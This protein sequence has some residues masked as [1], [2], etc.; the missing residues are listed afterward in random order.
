MFQLTK[1]IVFLFTIL[2]LFCHCIKESTLEPI[3]QTATISATIIN[4]SDWQKYFI[5]LSSDSTEFHFVPGISSIYNFGDNQIFAGGGFLRR[6]TARQTV[7]D[8]LVINTTAA[9]L[10]EAVKTGRGSIATK[11]A[12]PGE[13]NI[14]FF[15]TVFYDAD[16]NRTTTADQI[17]LNGS[18]TLDALF[19]LDIE[20]VDHKL[21]KFEI[22]I[23]LNEE[24]DLTLN[25]TQQFTM[26]K[27]IEIA[28][29]QTEPVQFFIEQLPVIVMPIVR[30]TAAING[31]SAKPLTMSMVQNVFFTAGAAFRQ[32]QWNPYCEFTNLFSTEPPVSKSET[33][34]RAV[35][36]VELIF[37]IYQANGPYIINS[38]YNEII[39]DTLKSQLYIGS[40]IDLGVRMAALDSSL[41]D[42]LKKN[43]QNYREKADINGN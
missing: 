36:Q 3:Q 32:N 16:N 11:L 14:V 31:K 28:R 42:Y 10:T 21:K 26:N 39:T 19:K 37:K 23:N 9:A 43:L 4:D 2:P 35:I 6:I 25:S 20:I 13:K 8:Q 17:V 18:L 24:V 27:T 38:L 30:V 40:D 1:K 41:V 5:S 12:N 22:M 15:N 7:G 29:F 33:E 34:V